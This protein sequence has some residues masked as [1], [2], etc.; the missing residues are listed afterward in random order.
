MTQTSIRR[1]ATPKQAATRRSAIDE[2]LDPALFRALGDPTR[3]SLLACIA[4]CGRGCSVSEVAEC[5]SVD[6]SVVSRHLATLAQ[7]GALEATKEGRIVRYRVRYAELAASLRALADALEAC[8][9]DCVA[10]EC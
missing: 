7:A 4:K 8:G 6:F 1:P 3:V 2:R 9:P 10:C 5:C